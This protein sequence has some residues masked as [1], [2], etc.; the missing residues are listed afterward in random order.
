MLPTRAKL[1]LTH[2]QLNALSR[3]TF[4]ARKGALKVTVDRA[5]LSALLLDHSKIVTAF[6]NELEGYL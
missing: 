1:S 6:R 5:A 2:D 4:D 3:A